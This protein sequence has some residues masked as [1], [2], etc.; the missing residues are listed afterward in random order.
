M[1]E[2]PG[3][4]KTNWSATS[5][6]VSF[7]V[8]S[9][10]CDCKSLAV[11]EGPA[12][13]QHVVVLN[14]G[15]IYEL[16]ILVHEEPVH[17]SVLAKQL[18]FILS[19]DSRCPEISALTTTHRDQWAINREKLIKLSRQNEQNLKRIESAIL[20]LAFVDF[21]PVSAQQWVTLAICN[22][23]RNVWADKLTLT[24]FANGITSSSDDVR[25]DF[26]I[27]RS[28]NSDY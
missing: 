9:Q 11:S 18:E 13:P 25:F 24:S 23:A 15:H 3:W 19:G 27:S 17:P 1:F 2:C 6:R 7:G 12:G 20:V 16:D 22:D 28:G 21:E 4:A 8:A 26:P 14:N 5:S 10:Q